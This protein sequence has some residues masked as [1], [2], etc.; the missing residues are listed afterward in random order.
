[1]GVCV[2]ECVGE[3]VCGC[4]GGCGWVRNGVP[5]LTL[6]SLLHCVL[7]HSLARTDSSTDLTPR[8]TIALSLSVSL[9]Q[10][11]VTGVPCRCNT[12]NVLPAKYTPD[13]E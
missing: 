5:E 8:L 12:R 11:C 3:W 7:G 10:L 1:M 13:S 4:V 9:C 6:T 2:G